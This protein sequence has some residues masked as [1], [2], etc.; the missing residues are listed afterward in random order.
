MRT[1]VQGLWH[2]LNQMTPG[3][4]HVQRHLVEYIQ[5]ECETNLSALEEKFPTLKQ[6]YQPQKVA[7]KVLPPDLSEEAL[8]TLQEVQKQGY[9]GPA[10][11]FPPFA[12]TRED[13]ANKI[14]EVKPPGPDDPPEV[15][16]LAQKKERALKE[17]CAHHEKIAQ[18]TYLLDFPQPANWVDPPARAACPVKR[19]EFKDGKIQSLVDDTVQGADREKADN[20]QEN[21]DEDLENPQI[22]VFD[23]FWN[24]IRDADDQQPAWAYCYIC[25]SVKHVAVDCWVTA[26]AKRRGLSFNADKEP[27]GCALCQRF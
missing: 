23:A 17:I 15:K 18:E 3:D 2:T 9:K 10:D 27:L 25:F 12:G 24:L 13:I 1:E 21:L 5:L 4:S 6:V 11:M 22:A 8:N 26:E 14:T 16:T 20:V 7:D 19:I